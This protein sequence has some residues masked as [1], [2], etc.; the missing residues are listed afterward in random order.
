[1]KLID[2]TKKTDKEL[3]EF[4]DASRTE[5]AKVVIESRSKEVRD[6]KVIGRLKKTISRALTIAREREIAKM[7]AAE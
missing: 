2:I 4:I 1:M 3:M 6:T 5:L 7:E